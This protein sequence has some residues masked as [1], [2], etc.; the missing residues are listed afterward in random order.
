MINLSDYKKRR[1]LELKREREQQELEIR[2]DFK[3]SMVRVMKIRSPKLRQ[4]SVLRF[5][6]Q[7]Y[8]ND[9]YYEHELS[10]FH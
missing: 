1:M 10:R 7:L 3:K 2:S 4:D 9:K 5:I 6:I 8:E